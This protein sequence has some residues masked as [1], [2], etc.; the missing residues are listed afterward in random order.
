M[1]TDKQ[2]AANRANGA[3]S[4]GPIT[5]EGTARRFGVCLATVPVTGMLAQ[6]L[7]REGESRDLFDELVGIF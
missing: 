1:A 3:R 5:P 4:R 2:I 7:L 6:A